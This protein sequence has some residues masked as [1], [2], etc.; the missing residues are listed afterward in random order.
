MVDVTPEKRLLELPSIIS[1]ASVCIAVTWQWVIEYIHYVVSEAQQTGFFCNA[2]FSSV[3]KSIL[4]TVY[5]NAM[6][7]TID[8]ACFN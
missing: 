3:F 6:F 7:A 2:G 1:I 5:G 4:V 8:P